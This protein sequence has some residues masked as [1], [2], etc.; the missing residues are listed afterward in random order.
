MSSQKSCV[1]KQPLTPFVIEPHVSS[2]NLTGQAHFLEGNLELC[3]SL[4]YNKDDL[5]LPTSSAGSIQRRNGLWEHTCFEAFVSQPDQKGYWEINLSPNGDWNFY[6]LSGYRENLQPEGAI[7]NLPI[8]VQFTDSGL[9]LSCTV[10]LKSLVDLT[11]P[12]EISLTAVLEHPVEGCS[13][14]AWNHCGEEADFHLRN[15]FT[16]L[17][18]DQ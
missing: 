7:E 3:Y 8:R 18:S 14:W 5:V 13:F 9:E 6:R 16:I 15:S 17:D 12:L 11:K 1:L 10:P 4:K 2:I